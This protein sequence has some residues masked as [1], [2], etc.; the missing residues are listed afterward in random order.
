MAGR[1]WVSVTALAATAVLCLECSAPVTKFTP[2]G[3][4]YAMRKHLPDEIAVYVSPSTPERPYRV[5]GSIF[6]PDMCPSLDQDG[7]LQELRKTAAK[8]GVDG[9]MNVAFVT[10]EGKVVLIG[11]GCGGPPSNGE[12][13]TRH[14][15]K[16]DAFVWED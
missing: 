16:A 3:V 2:T 9:V 8:K 6:V 4:K 11:C 14:E 1:M 5:V 7:Q 15:A 12:S 10:R 13:I